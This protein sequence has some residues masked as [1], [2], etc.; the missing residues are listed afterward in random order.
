MREALPAGNRLRERSPDSARDPL[1]CKPSR[2]STALDLGSVPAATAEIG[3]R[4]PE[5]REAPERLG[6]PNEYQVLL[7]GDPLA[8]LCR[9]PVYRT[10]PGRQR[11][12]SHPRFAC[13]LLGLE[14]VK[15]ESTKSGSCMT[16]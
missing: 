9:P 11:D 10:P 8:S 6:P 12:M 15:L 16:A 2:H 14:R 7:P 13:V 1:A 5:M 4:F 3:A